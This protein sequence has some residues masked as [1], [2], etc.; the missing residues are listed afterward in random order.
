MANVGKLTVMVGA[1]IGNLQKELSGAGKTVGSFASKTGTAI[2][3]LGTKVIIGGG[4]LGAFAGIGKGI[5]LAADFEQSEVALT[6]M[7]GSADTAK[8]VLSNLTKFAAETPF[9]MPEL[10][11]AT[12]QLTAFG[13]SSDDLLPTL[14][15]IGDISS[16]IGA[17]INDIALVYGKAKV[18]GRLFARDINEL[19]GRGIPV[20]QELAKQFGVTETEVGKLVE[21]GQVNF[22]HLEKAF[23]SL[24]DEGGDF[25]GLM[26]AQSQTVTGLW[27]TL[28]DNV[29]LA[30]RDIGLTIIDEFNFK[31]VMR[32]LISFTN[33]AGT[34]LGIF[35]K[36][37]DT[38]WELIQVGAAVQLDKVKAGFIAT[39]AT[40]ILA[41]E[42]F[43]KDWSAILADIGNKSPAGE[44]IQKTGSFFVS[45][46]EALKAP[47]GASITAFQRSQAQIAEG[48]PSVIKSNAEIASKFWSGIGDDFGKAFGLSTDKDLTAQLN[49]L[50]EKLS[51][52]R[53]KLTSEVRGGREFTEALIDPLARDSDTPLG[54]KKAKQLPG[55]SNA[56]LTAEETARAAAA[57]FGSAEAFSLTGSQNQSD[58]RQI[59]T[60]QAELADNSRKTLTEMERVR[61]AVEE[62]DP[63]ARIGSIA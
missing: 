44:D 48:L 39:F 30:L 18:Q 15:R 53:D 35:M 24:T 63:L 22:G 16:G 19:T 56:K 33:D 45:F 38:H 11:Q 41:L 9:E 37:W 50:T 23:Q 32:G 57:E 5:K 21:S 55:L 20:I 34:E 42:R 3:G 10:I 36:T 26:K 51:K 46:W 2:A 6:T 52:E 28:K 25:A 62:N 8:S 1:N 43:S 31:D 13:V 17:P 27:S 58:L 4:V 59:V 54:K 40:A 29:N 61:R 12:K 47:P 49:A 7:L 14:R 60:Y